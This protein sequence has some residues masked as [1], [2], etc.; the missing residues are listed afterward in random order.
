VRRR[1]KV[2]GDWRRLCNEE[3]RNMYS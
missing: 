1:D 2:T 3:L